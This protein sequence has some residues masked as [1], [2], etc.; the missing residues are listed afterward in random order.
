MKKSRRNE[1]ASE[2]VWEGSAAAAQQGMEVTDAYVSARALRPNQAARRTMGFTN[3]S[4]LAHDPR[5]VRPLQVREYFPALG[6]C[7][8]LIGCRGID[9]RGPRRCN[10]GFAAGCA[11]RF[12]GLN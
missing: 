3:P 11:G 9:R 8:D 5:G 4:A 1:A 6:K 2:R 12:N 10:T 7:V